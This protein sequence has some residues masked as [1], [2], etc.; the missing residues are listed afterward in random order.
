M[1]S[2]R[3]ISL[4]YAGLS[5]SLDAAHDLIVISKPDLDKTHSPFVFLKSS[6]SDLDSSF[7]PLSHDFTQ[8]ER[9]LTNQVMSVLQFPVAF[10]AEERAIYRLEG[11]EHALSHY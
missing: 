6:T 4:A 3:L 2:L 7:A 5:C 8:P 1:E 11:E 10:A 9:Y